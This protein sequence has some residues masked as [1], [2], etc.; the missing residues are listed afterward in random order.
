MPIFLSFRGSIKAFMYEYR[1]RK[2]LKKSNNSIRWCTQK[3]VK[4]QKHSARN[5]YKGA[6]VTLSEQDDDEAVKKDYNLVLKLMLGMYNLVI[7]SV[8]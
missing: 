1:L 2:S 5:M 4:E 7:Y 8:S 6:Q 3:L